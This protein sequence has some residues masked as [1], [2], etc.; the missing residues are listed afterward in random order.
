MDEVCT[1]TIKLT[2]QELNKLIWCVKGAQYILDAYGHKPEE[3]WN[4][5]LI[6]IQEDMENIENIIKEERTKRTV[7]KR[8]DPKKEYIEKIKGVSP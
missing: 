1:V 4:K 5:T 2:E 3:G 8:A 7:D 6:K